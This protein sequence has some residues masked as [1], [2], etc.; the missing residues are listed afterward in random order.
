MNKWTES[1]KSLIEAARIPVASAA[2]PAAYESVNDVPLALRRSLVRL[3]NEGMTARQIGVKLALPE[4]WVLL[5]VETP[6]RA[7][8]H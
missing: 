4:Q 5:F 2:A 7:T 3:Y 1:M 6:A 8:K